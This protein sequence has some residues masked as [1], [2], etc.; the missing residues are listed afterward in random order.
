VTLDRDWVLS[1]LGLDSIEQAI[2]GEDISAQLGISYY[3]PPIPMQFA[4]ALAPINCK[5]TQH[6]VESFALYSKEFEEDE[7]VVATEKLHGSQIA[8][9][10]NSDGLQVSSKGFFKKGFSLLDSECSVYWNALRNSGLIPIIEDFAKHHDFIQVFGEV[11]P[12][13]GKDWSYGYDKPTI[14]VF[15]LE[16]DGIR[17]GAADG[18]IGGHAIPWVPLVYR[19]WFDEAV[20]R[21]LA[22]GKETVSNKALHIREGIVIE[23]RQPRRSKEGFPLYVKLINPKFKESDDA[24]T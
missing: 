11:I 1:K 14:K 20:L 5:Y 21:E 6:D 9:L 15:R 12:A 18:E 2:I 7:V 4:G 19:G 8:I 23:P 17:Y 13:Q 24:L 10:R 3:E 22:K 16:L